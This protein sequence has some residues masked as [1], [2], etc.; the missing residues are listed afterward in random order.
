MTN[1]FWKNWIVK[2]TIENRNYA[3]AIFTFF[4][5]ACTSEFGAL[6]LI[7]LLIILI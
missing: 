1:I 4:N 7:T 6:F 2:G 3:V 5:S